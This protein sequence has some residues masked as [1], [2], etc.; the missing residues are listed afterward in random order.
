MRVVHWSHGVARE[1]YRYVSRQGVLEPRMTIKAFTF[2]NKEVERI[3]LPEALE[4]IEEGAF[5][6]CGRI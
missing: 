1:G 2:L 4:T 6:N 3:V 5:Q